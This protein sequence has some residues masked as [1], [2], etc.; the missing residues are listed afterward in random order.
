MAKALTHADGLILLRTNLPHRL[1]PQTLHSLV[2]A[3]L[4]YG[5]DNNQTAYVPMT[6]ASKISM[7]IFTDG[8][9]LSFNNRMFRLIDADNNIVT[10]E[11]F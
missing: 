5:S 11:T 8:Y 3:W 6:E 7:L 9:S 2:C 1:H 10:Q 4:A